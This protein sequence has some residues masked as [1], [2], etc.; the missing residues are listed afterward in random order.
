M[1]LRGG[2]DAP[3]DGFILDDP[4]VAVEIGD[5]RQAVVERD[6]VAEAVAGFQL[7]ELHQLVGDGDAVDLLA[8]FLQLAHAPEDAAV[9]FQ[10]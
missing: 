7:V 9:L 3:Q 10:S 1:L 6:Q 8:A 5:L 4:D 2:D